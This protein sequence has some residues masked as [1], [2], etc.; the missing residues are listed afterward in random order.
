[1]TNSRNFYGASSLVLA[2]L[3]SAFALFVP[4]IALGVW[5]MWVRSPW[6]HFATAATY[7]SSVT[8]HGSFFG[9]IFPTLVAMG[10]GYACCA[11]GLA[12]P[13]R[14]MAWAWTGFWMVVTGSVLVLVPVLFGQAGVLY[15]FYPPLTANAWYYGGLV[16]VII[17][18]WIWVAVLVVNMVGWKRENPGKPVPL[19]MFASVASA[20]VWLWTSLGVLSEVVFYLL[21]VALGWRTQVD[22]GLGRVLFSW[23][24]HG[25][26]YFWLLPAYI[27]YYTL[28]PQAAGSRLYSDIMGRLAFLLFVVFAMPIGIHH[29]FADPQVGSGT[30]FLHTVFTIMVVVP[31]LITVFSITATMEIS[32]RL[33]GGKGVFGWVAALPWKEPTVLA[34]G[35][36]FIMLG[37]GGAGGI[38]NM[39]YGMNASIHNTQF[40]TAHFHMIYPGAVVI[41][42]F[43]IIYELWPKLTGR[44]LWSLRLVR[45]QLWLWFIGIMLLTIPWHV[46]GLLGQPRRMAFYDY[47]DP[48]LARIAPWVTP[49]VIGGFIALLSATL[50]LV[51]MALSHLPARDENIG[52]L[53]FALS[54]N[55]PSRIPAA[56]NGFGYWNVLM[57]VVLGVNYGIP[58]AQLLLLKN[59]HT[60]PGYQVGSHPEADG[61]IPAVNREQRDAQP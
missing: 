34:T 4:G 51:N 1:M 29:L 23:T 37:I 21:P 55:P 8:A 58:I 54:V 28:A 19:A 40:V 31:T 39:S 11:A 32:G 53:Q 50:L 24:L 13:I 38:I 33:H 59:A 16:T 14:G 42:Y 20:L 44:P 43:V 45:T 27:A 17:G 61:A 18:S 12:R 6:G 9:Y 60:S 2:H 35:L 57:L 41:M 10:F 56:L 3:W 52:P 26:V 47:S 49:S 36:S 48:V 22:A 30:K 15:T 46:A 25:I 7:Y 5:Q